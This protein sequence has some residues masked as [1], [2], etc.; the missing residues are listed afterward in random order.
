MLRP[1]IAGSIMISLVTLVGIVVTA[2]GV[3]VTAFMAARKIRAERTKIAVTHVWDHVDSRFSFELPDVLKL[4]AKNYS[5]HDVVVDL[6]ALY[7]PGIGDGKFTPEGLQNSTLTNP[8]THNVISIPESDKNHGAE[9]RVT[10]RPGEAI[11]ST[12]D[13]R[14]VIQ[15]G[16]TM[17]VRGKPLRVRAWCQDTLDHKSVGKWFRLLPKQHGWMWQ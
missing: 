14:S 11:S 4:T 13:A 16:L 8:K 17:R 7:I 15:L 5:K 2:I 9:Q 3:A 12:F 10:L 6:L 1:H